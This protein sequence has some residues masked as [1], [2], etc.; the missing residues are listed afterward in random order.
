M[1]RRTW[2]EPSTA[3]LHTVCRQ[4]LMFSQRLWSVDDQSRGCAAGWSYKAWSFCVTFLKLFSSSVA[5][6]SGN[7]G[8]RVKH[9][10]TVAPQTA[11]LQE[12]L[13]WP[14]HLVASCAHSEAECGGLACCTRC[15]E[16]IQSN[17]Q[18]HSF[19]YFG[20]TG[21][22]GNFRIF[23][24]HKSRWMQLCTLQRLLRWW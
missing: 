9:G 24:N 12:H 4:N 23:R 7:F 5:K 18:S 13:H 2:R 1:K 11:L 17:P 6:Q 14:C 20:I 3:A 15:T 22:P 21:F 16:A 19:I 10:S 8:L